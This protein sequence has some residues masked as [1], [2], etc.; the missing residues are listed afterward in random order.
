MND[1]ARTQVHVIATTEYPGDYA[2][3]VVATELSSQIENDFSDSANFTAEPIEH[4]LWCLAT[5]QGFPRN[6][7]G[8][9]HLGRWCFD[10]DARSPAR[11]RPGSSV[12]HHWRFVFRVFQTAGGQTADELG[13]LFGPY[14]PYDSV[15]KP[16][17]ADSWETGQFDQCFTTLARSSSG[18]ARHDMGSRKRDFIS[19]PLPYGH[20]FRNAS[21]V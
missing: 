7:R 19:T 6:V 10:Q 14:D 20:T 15:H 18:M 16:G 13:Y 9:L 17:E 8:R 2:Q 5:D 21:M 3:N 4:R 1:R 12:H 11:C